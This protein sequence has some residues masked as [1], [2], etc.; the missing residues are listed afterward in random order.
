MG[1]GCG[2]GLAL[3][4]PRAGTRQP[5]AASA[6]SRYALGAYGV[7]AARPGAGG[8]PDHRLA[9]RARRRGRCA[10]CAAPGG[11]AAGC[12]R[13][14]A[15]RARRQWRGRCAPG[16]LRQPNRRL[17]LRA[18]HQRRGRY[19]PER[20]HVHPRL[21]TLSPGDGGDVEDVVRCALLDMLGAR[22]ASSSCRGRRWGCTP[23]GPHCHR[24]RHA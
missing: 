17:A 9:L 24:R 2:L 14:L 23:R 7:S 8:E 15:L 4:R 12:H 21:R 19:A 10:P 3:G 5:L 16:G 1:Q 18:R 13:R 11:A 20:P 6:A 22:L